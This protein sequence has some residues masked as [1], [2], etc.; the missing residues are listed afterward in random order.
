MPAQRLAVDQFTRE[1]LLLHADTALSG[2]KVAAALDA[3]IVARTP[4]SMIVDNGTEF[5]SK[6]WT[7]GLA[8]RCSFG[9]HPAGTPG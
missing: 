9:F 4:L 6:P 3:V 8:E 5:A 2:E 1:C 7:P